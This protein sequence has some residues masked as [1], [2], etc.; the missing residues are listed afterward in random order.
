MLD[1]DGYSV[2]AILMRRLLP[3]RFYPGRDRVGSSITDLKYSDTVT[4]FDGVDYYW[5]P[6]IFQALRHL[7]HERPQIVVFEW[8]TSTVA[9]SYLALAIFARITGATVIVEFHETLDTAEAGMVLPG[10]Y[11]RVMLRPIL[12][13]AQGFAVHSRFDCRE[14]AERYPLGGKP[15]A[16][17]AH[18][19]YDH[20]VAQKKGA[21]APDTPHQ[22]LYFGTIRPYK[23]LE[24]LIEAFD[25][26]TEL[27]AEG[28]HL[29][30]VGETWEG[31]TLPAEMIE[32]SPHRNL[33]TF[34]NRYVTDA[35]AEE[36]FSRTDAV[37]LPYLR[38]SASG[39]LHIA[40]SYGLPVIV[41]D[42]G[43]LTEV[44]EHYKGAILIPPRDVGALRAAIQ[45][46]D[47]DNVSRYEDPSS[48]TASA[49][50][51]IS[52]FDQS[53]WPTQEP[54]G[55]SPVCID[56]STML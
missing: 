49:R 15:I 43:G 4:V 38:A 33:I 47:R 30:V 3:R 24:F 34:V 17:V 35:E 56:P 28:F 48:W 51:L 53:R 1:E 42:V 14:I 2:T 41:T 16:V 54:A 52:L 55:D 8:W 23:G 20:F 9:H 50:Q 7:W 22:L 29:T 31:W 10:I 40:M 21:A 5:L 19:P 11:A 13:L 12:W 39:P 45:N 26:L 32:N 27:E 25:G 6:S 46:M 36:Y 44:V 37:I 18:G